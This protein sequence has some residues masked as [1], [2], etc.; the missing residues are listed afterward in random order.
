MTSADTFEMTRMTWV[1]DE[2]DMVNLVAAIE[3]APVVV[4]DLETTGLDEHAWT[5]GPKNGG[6]A[7]RIALAS[8]TL[9]AYDEFGEIDGDP[10]NLVLPLS[11]PD[12]P[13]LGKWRS[14]MA[15]VAEAMLGKRLVGH[16]VKF[17]NRWIYATTGI[18]L[19]S[20]TW[21]DT[22]ISSHLLDETV[23]TKLKERAPDTFGV[24]RWDDVD[25]TYPGAA[26][27]EPLFKLG[28]YAA[29]DTYW[30]W[31]LYESHR[32]R[33]L[34]DEEPMSSEEIED[35]RLGMLARWCAM[36]TTA[37]LTGI[38][39]R[40]MALDRPWVESTIRDLERTQAS[41]LKELSG[42]YIAD[43]LDPDN[44][45]FAPTSHW[46]KRWAEL[47]VENGDLKVAALTPTGKPQ[48]SKSVLGRQARNGS[49]VAASL[50]AYRDATKRLEF[51]RAWLQMTTKKGRI[52]TTYHAGSVVSGR[53]SSSGPNMQQVTKSLRPAFVPSKGYV[54]ADLDYSQ[55]ELRVAA[56]ISGSDPMMSAYVNG[57]DL[58]S[59]MASRISGKPVDQVTPEERQAGKA[60][61]FG[62]LYGMG[63]YGFK[64]YAED[65]YGVVFTDQEAAQVHQTFFETW[66]GIRQWHAQAV[67]RLHET[68]Q[69]IS[70]IGRVRRLPGVF[71]GNDSEVGFSERAAINSPVQGMASDIMQI[72]ASCIEGNIP[73]VEPVRRA[74]LVGTVHDSIVVEVPEDGWE[75]VVAQC[76]EAM[77]QT[78][79]QVLRKMGCDFDIPLQADATVGTRWSLSDVGSV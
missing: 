75:E 79:P 65:A 56:F 59:I 32:E 45:S 57:E 34:P 55:I 33:M 36:P 19:A 63:A 15:R 77:E 5:D 21:W 69:V 61:N 42:R 23:S 67:K 76:K 9:P 58:H 54:I 11:H 53:L 27:D 50:L 4:Y 71:S 17:D 24:E 7:A 68:G 26:E 39:Q 1:N 48:W 49:V 51:L 20:S 41:T 73:G 18:D 72:A 52:H 47:A 78:V 16:N 35:A 43:D 8:F 3:D 64:L 25:L 74:R 60:A 62:L 31:R 28:E 46:F 30:T 38:E 66:N 13:W 6:V 29:R 40:G 12:S 70:P 37:T 44:P 10:V 14:T 2:S 22:Q